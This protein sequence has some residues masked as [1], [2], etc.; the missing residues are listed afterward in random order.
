ME[1]ILKTSNLLKNKSNYNPSDLDTKV[2]VDDHNHA[3][4]LWSSIRAGTKIKGWSKEE[5]YNVH[6]LIV[7]EM[8]RRGLKH[9]TPLLLSSRFKPAGKPKGFYIEQPPAAPKPVKPYIQLT[10]PQKAL[11]MYR[12]KVSTEMSLSTIASEVGCSK[13]AVIYWQNKLGLR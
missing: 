11:I 1:C 5:V 2:L 7:K 3:H 4:A 9:K 13:P 12:T 8:I 10:D 6:E